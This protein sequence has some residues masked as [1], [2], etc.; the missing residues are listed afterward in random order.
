MWVR[1]GGRVGPYANNF[2]HWLTG[3]SRASGVWTS[4]EG[5]EPSQ[6]D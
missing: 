5:L 2:K 4:S 6:L 3:L 1:L